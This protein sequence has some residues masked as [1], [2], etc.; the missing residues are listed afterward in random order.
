MNYLNENVRLSIDAKIIGEKEEQNEFEKIKL[1]NSS[2]NES[3]SSEI[4]NKEEYINKLL[5][6]C[7]MPSRRQGWSLLR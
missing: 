7:R 2:S 6:R 4:L 3:S 1:E 5:S